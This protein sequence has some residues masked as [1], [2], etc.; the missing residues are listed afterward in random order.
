ML[1]KHD[2]E[3]LLVALN[4]ELADC[5]AHG[6]LHLVGGAVMCMVYESR[7]ATRDVDAHFVP[8]RVMREAAARI[9]QRRNLEP[10]WLNDAVKAFLSPKGAFRGFLSLSH[11]EVFVP[12]P[13]YL[14]AMKCTALRLGAE[15][16]DEADVRYLLRYLNIERYEDAIAVVERYY[17]P[18]LCPQKMYY[19]LEEILTPVA[20]L[21]VDAHRGGR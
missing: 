8:T 14:L 19:A 1:N 7:P 5:R 3:S 15:F 4:E 6:E 13:E 17:P 21:S 10:D 9:A 11:L 12:H 18:K 2:I 16:H 20:R